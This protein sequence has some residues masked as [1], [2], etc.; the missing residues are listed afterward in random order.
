MSATAAYNFFFED[1]ALVW[2]PVNSALMQYHNSI[3]KFN[4]DAMCIVSLQLH[5]ALIQHLL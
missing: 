2:L 4:T 1:P 3:T 5:S